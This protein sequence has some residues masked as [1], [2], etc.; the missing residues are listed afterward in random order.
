MK[1]KMKLTNSQIAFEYAIYMMVGSYFK[2]A[3]CKS[4]LLEQS[5]KLQYLEQ[6]ERVQLQMEDT[7]ISFVEKKM[8]PLLPQDLWG[9]DVK[10]IFEPSEDKE[11]NHVLFVG[12]KSVLEV[13]CIY[14]GTRSKIQYSF[15]NKRQKKAPKK[16]HKVAQLLCEKRILFSF[17]GKNKG[18]K[19]RADKK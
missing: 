2:S 13:H 6:K 11:L 15:W 18:K 4:R 9:E 10:V 17:S 8:V 7:V 12:K 14:Q 3:R 16:F 5:M 1:V 19:E